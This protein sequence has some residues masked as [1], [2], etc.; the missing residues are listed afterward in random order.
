VSNATAC[1]TYQ[2]NRIRLLAGII[3]FNADRVA[4]KRWAVETVDQLTYDQAARLIADGLAR[5]MD[6]PGTDMELLA[7]R[8]FNAGRDTCLLDLWT[9]RVLCEL[10]NGAPQ[11]PAQDRADAAMWRLVERADA[12]QRVKVW[13]V[14]ADGLRLDRFDPRWRPFIVDVRSPVDRCV[15]TLSED[16]LLA[17]YDGPGGN[18]RVVDSLCPS[19]YAK[20]GSAPPDLADGI[21]RITS[22]AKAGPPWTLVLGHHRDQHRCHRAQIAQALRDAGHQAVELTRERTQPCNSTVSCSSAA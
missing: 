3:G 19:S 17:W 14:G 13:L 6:L 7:V 11:Y 18:Y 1:T 12:S 8:W 4:A 20:A 22:I 2:L 21:R 9:D 15:G 5:V 16:A 10:A